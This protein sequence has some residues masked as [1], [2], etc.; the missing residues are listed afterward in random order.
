MLAGEHLNPETLKSV[1]DKGTTDVASDR[2]RIPLEGIQSGSQLLNCLQIIDLN[3]PLALRHLMAL[4]QLGRA[5]DG[6]SFAS[7]AR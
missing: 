4:F 2:L 6:E 5:P 3:Y 7:S 1:H